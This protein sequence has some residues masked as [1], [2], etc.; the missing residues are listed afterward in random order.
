MPATEPF[1]KQLDD[2]KQAT[3]SVEAKE[4]RWVFNFTAIQFAGFIFVSLVTA[5]TWLYA[6]GGKQIEKQVEVQGI[7]DNQTRFEAKIIELT[8]SLDSNDK[9]HDAQIKAI[10]DNYITFKA[11]LE[12][13]DKK[14]DANAKETDRKL[15][16]V[17]QMIKGQR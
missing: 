2:L 17:I 6:T 4:K 1:Q 11:Q 13:L 3:V 10:N 5:G 7:K 9:R 15:D 14:V 12:A 16:L 8:Q